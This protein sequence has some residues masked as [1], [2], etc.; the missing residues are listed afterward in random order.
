[1]TGLNSLQ[2]AVSLI[3][4]DQMCGTIYYR[5]TQLTQKQEKKLSSIIITSLQGVSVGFFLNSNVMSV[6]KSKTSN[7][8]KTKSR[9][10]LSDLFCGSCLELAGM[11]LLRES[12]IRRAVLCSKFNISRL[13]LCY[14]AQQNLKPQT[15]I[16]VVS[17]L[18]RFSSPDSA[19]GHIKGDV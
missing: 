7:L 17:L 14:L 15:E 2:F 4:R 6:T 8:K 1:M 5:A 13:S 9:E 18:T 11:R 16:V 3:T 19:H 10:N 12:N